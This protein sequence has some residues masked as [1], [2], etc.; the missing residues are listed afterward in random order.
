MQDLFG[1][2]AAYIV[3]AFGITALVLG[4]LIVSSLLFARHWRRRAEEETNR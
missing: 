4:Y 1:K 3:P 2:Y